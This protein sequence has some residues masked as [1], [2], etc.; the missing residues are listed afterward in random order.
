MKKITQSIFLLL[1][2]LGFSQNAPINFEVGGFGADWTYTVFENGPNTPVAVVANPD[3]SGINTSATVGQMT[4][5]QVGMPWAGCETLHGAGIGTFTLSASNAIVKIMVWKSVISDV[6]I[7]FSVNDGG[8]TGELKVANTLINQWEELT[9]NFSGKIGEPTSTNIDQIVIFPDF[10]FARTSD[11][12]FYFDN[13]TFSS[14]SP[15]LTDP[16][17]AAPNPTLPQTDVISMFSNVYTNVPVDTWQTNWSAATLEDVQVAGNDTKKYTGLNFVGIETVSSQIDATNMTAFNVDVWS[18]DFTVFK[19]KLVDFGAD[20]AFGGGDDVE[21]EITFNAPAQST[22]VSYHIPLALFENLTTRNH[23][24]QLI[25]V[26]GG[27]KVYIDNVYFSNEPVV[28]I[29]TDPTVAAP[30]PTLPAEDVI[31]MFSNVYTNVT[32]DTWHT[33]WSAATLADVQVE[34]ND[35]KKYTGLNFVGIETVTAQLDVTDMTHFNIDVWSPDFTVFKVKLVDFGADGAFAGGDDVEHEITFNAPA[36]SE[37]VTYHIPMADFINLTTK[38]H[39]AQLILVGGGA[40]VYVDNVYFSDETVVVPLTDPIVAAPDPTLPQE[41]VIS[42][43]SNVYTNVPVDT[44]QTNWSAATLEDVQVAGND[45]KK[46]TG[47]NFVGIETVASQIDATDMT[48]FNVDVWSPDFTVFKVKLVDFGADGA[49]AGGDDVEHEITFNN[50]AQSTWVSYHIPLALFENLVNRQHIA[51]LIFVGGGAKVYVDNVYFGSEPVVVIPTD[52][53]VAAPDPT[54]PANQVMSM[55]SN[56]YTNVPVDTWHTDWSAA[57]LADVQVE[58]ND[59]K[60]YTGLNFVGIETVSSQLDITNMTHFNIDVWSP[61]FTVFKV[62]LV[63]FGADGGFAG[64]DD[65]EH[66]ITFNAPAQSEWIT[67]HIP[68]TDFTNL[69]TKEHIS[70]L[71]LV[72]GGAKVYVDNV[73]FNGLPLSVEE[74]STSKTTMYPNPANNVLHFSATE[75]IEEITIYSVLGQKVKSAAP[76]ATQTT[77]DVSS[78]NSGIYIVTT[79]SNGTAT[80]KR[81]V[82]Q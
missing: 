27:G 21:H 47:L 11:N 25:F 34:G 66:E 2:S 67:Y 19:V 48:T 9:F 22:W 36:Q 64:G 29:P 55:F 24:S 73:Y 31:S 80:S 75:A 49:F 71:I 44:W 82:I 33:D 20:T 51:Q 78:L 53:T 10:N 46:Y 23:I 38:Q 26:G 17:V 45:T 7:K 65:V 70:Q 61:D 52:P 69:V 6:G 59:T 77:V 41:D 1:F 30:N 8:S 13:I 58:G 76:N 68:I 14:A 72:G 37:W 43:F 15:T 12:V 16:I 5:L 18:P 4:A 50:P 54:L 63:D 62:K 56:V 42:M 79:L 3:M 35:T 74:I 39:I 28:V 40:K 32:V 60:K 81:L 57:T